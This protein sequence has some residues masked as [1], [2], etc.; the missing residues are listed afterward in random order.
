MAKYHI[1]VADPPYSFNDKLQFSEVKRS[2]ADNYD[3]MTNKDILD[4][5]VEKIAE[6]NAVLALWVPSSLLQLGLDIMKRWGFKQTQTHIWVKTKKNVEGLTL[7]NSLAFGMGRLFRQT[8]ELCLLGTRGSPYKN[9]KNK[10]KRSVYFAPNLKHSQKPET[11]QAEL[12]A[13][14][15]GKKIKKCEIFARRIR[16]GWDCWGN[17]CEGTLGEDIRDTLSR[18]ISKK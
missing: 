8:H 16:P 15:P 5:P 14:F 12:E 2:A 3:V 1:I 10:S 11:L 13:M 6:N 4:L 9:L 18:I 7:D 17:Q